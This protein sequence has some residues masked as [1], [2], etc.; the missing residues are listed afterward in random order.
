VV[1]PASPPAVPA[2]L[3]TGASPAAH[4]RRA[5]VIGPGTRVATLHGYARLTRSLG[6]DPDRLL[7]SV[8]LRPADLTEPDAWLPAAA[9]GRLLDRTAAESG[10]ED[11]GLLLAQ[12]RRLSTWGR[13]SVVLREEPDLRSAL[14]LLIR[15]ERSL[16][17]VVRYDLAERLG[18]GTV[19]VWVEIDE[20][21]PVRQAL[22]LAVG[23]I[24]GLVR[25]LRDARWEPRAVC[26]EHR[27]PR[28]PTQHRALLG[29]AVFFDQD[30]TGVVLTSGDLD[31]PNVLA[32]RD[33][34]QLRAY[35]LQFLEFLPAPRQ[36]E[37]LHRV[38]EVVQDLLPMGKCTM[39]RVARALGTTPRT[40][41]RH[42]AAE[43]E[44][45]AGIVEATRGALAT[46]YLA[47]DRH[48]LTDVA[49]L[50]GFA[51]HSAFSRWFRRR[52]GSSPSEW[53]AM[54]RSAG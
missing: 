51:A 44:S 7:A 31:A 11:F 43:G 19:T 34:P 47:T 28:R 1:A 5:A 32:T 13:L 4:A 52:F 22:E 38:R 14:E 21:V 42:L 9:V 20:P 45:F 23:A 54:A 29:P 18:V 16:T 24:V 35:T 36:P 8:R 50:L 26:L 15:Y 39:P 30:F 10:R 46:R 27:A 48:S 41:H 12:E 49:Y 25:T 37:L 6:L 2:P 17:D 33:D 40:L 3:S 53:R